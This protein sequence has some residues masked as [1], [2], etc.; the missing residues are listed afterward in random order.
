MPKTRVLNVTNQ[1]LP[2]PITLGGRLV[3]AGAG[4]VIPRAIAVVMAELGGDEEV[5]GIWSVSAQPERD[6]ADAHTTANVDATSL[7]TVALSETA[8][9]GG[10]VLTYNADD[11]VAE[12]D[13]PSSG[14][15]LATSGAE[16]VALGA[17]A[18]L[19]NGTAAARSNHVHPTTGLAVLA[20][21]AAQT[22]KT[23]DSATG[24]T[25][26]VNVSHESNGVLGTGFG[27][28]IGLLDGALAGGVL[29]ATFDAV[30]ESGGG[31]RLSIGLKDAGSPTPNERLTLSSAGRLTVS[32][33][34]KPY[35]GTV[36]QVT[37]G[38]FIVTATAGC[39]AFATNGRKPGESVGNGTGVLCVY[40][41]T[42][43]ISC[44]DGTTLAA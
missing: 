25:R 32:E 40:D 23:S 37:G 3:R 11:E 5:R 21:S 38:V 36:S 18:A 19:G 29:R 24:V 20:A 9:T 4:V 33:A 31:T 2:L 15:A 13:T 28:G 35:T 43:W 26:S 14:V 6:A 44:F 1:I 7:Q 16:P 12:W 30:R 42:N 22:L 8:P 39:L 17:A 41:G 34:V 27:V 10:Q